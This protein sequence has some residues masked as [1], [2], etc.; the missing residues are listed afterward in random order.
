M[1]TSFGTY[2]VT[3]SDRSNGRS[4]V[5]VVRAAIAGGV[6]VVQLREK[7]T[8]VRE[9]LAVARELRELTADAGVPLVVNDRVDLAAAVDADGVHLGDDDL[10]L[11]VARTQLGDDALV[12]RSV[13]TVVAAERAEERGADYLGVGAVYRTSSKETAPEETEIGLD[14]VAAIRDA[15]SVPVVGIGGVTAERA[16]D[17]V[18]AG[19]DGIAVITE[20]T[21]AS[22]PEAATRRLADAVAAGRARR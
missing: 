15:V 12:G 11:G 6:D 19:A 13:S 3:Q 14:R 8:S 21:R 7:H 10:P 16:A 17:V 4:T 2:L 5:E 22:D 9:R 20:I 1:N 18:A